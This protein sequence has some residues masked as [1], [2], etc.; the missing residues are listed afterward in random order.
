MYTFNIV[1]NKLN[2][3][4]PDGAILNLLSDCVDPVHLLLVGR[5]LDEV[6]CVRLSDD[7]KQVALNVAFHTCERG[8]VKM[9][10]WSKKLY[11]N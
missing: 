7:F 1:P 11:Q 6:M 9:K 4:K 3:L 2:E 5:S 8:D 10:I